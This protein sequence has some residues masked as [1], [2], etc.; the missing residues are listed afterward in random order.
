METRLELFV[1]VII[2]EVRV[3]LRCNCF[4]QDFWEEWQVRNGTNVIESV[5]VRTRFLKNL[6]YCSRFERWWD[7]TRG[8]GGV[9]AFSFEEAELRCKPGTRVGEWYSLGFYG[10]KWVQQSMETI[11]VIGNSLVVEGK[12]MLGNV[13][14]PMVRVVTLM[15]LMLRKQIICDDLVLEMAKI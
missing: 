7:W 1:K 3:N 15:S 9:D 4:F 8:K 12:L 11:I 2:G 6:S 5:G 10:S 13:S 14:M